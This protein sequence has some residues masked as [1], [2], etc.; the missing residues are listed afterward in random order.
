MAYAIAL[1][2][3]SAVVWVGGMFF[4]YVALRP[5]AVETLEPPPRLKLWLATFKRFFLWVWLAVITILAT[6]YWMVFN[7]F[8]GFDQAG[9]H[10]G[11]MHIAGII[12]VLIYMHVFF[13]PYRRMRQAV[14]A[15]DFPAAGN[16]L[17]QIRTLV[18]VNLLIGLGVIT[19]ASAGR[20]LAL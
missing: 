10:V 19:V 2:I 14:N 17:S 15:G 9:L 5:A 8:G 20:Y 12:M 16:K 4:A 13:A 3:L 18:G 7:V 1:H 11:V 6:G